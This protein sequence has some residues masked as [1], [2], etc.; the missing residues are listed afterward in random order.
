VTNSSVP[1]YHPVPKPS[2]PVITSRHKLRD[3]NFPST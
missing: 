1:S 3:S 2:A